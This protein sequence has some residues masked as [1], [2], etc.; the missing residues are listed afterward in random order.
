MLRYYKG[1]EINDRVVSEVFKWAGSAVEVEG[2]LTIKKIM[3]IVSN[4]KDV[5][6]IY[7]AY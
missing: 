1:L 7:A 3:R 4:F 2:K 6:A 5:G